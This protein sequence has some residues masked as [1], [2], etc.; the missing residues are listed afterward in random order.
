[1]EQLE[2]TRYKVSQNTR[3]CP[4]GQSWAYHYTG[5]RSEAAAEGPTSW[6]WSEMGETMRGEFLGN[7]VSEYIQLYRR[8]KQGTESFKSIIKY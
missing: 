4:S 3:N 8:D 7:S 5:P 2:Y 6:E 1:M